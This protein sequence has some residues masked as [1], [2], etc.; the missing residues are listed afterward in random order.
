MKGLNL[1]LYCRTVLLPLLGTINVAAFI[2]ASFLGLRALLACM[3]LAGVAVGGFWTLAPA[4]TADIFGPRA[5]ASNF[6]LIHMANSAGILA[7]NSGV[8]G[9]VYEWVAKRHGQPPGEC[10]GHSCFRYAGSKTLKPKTRK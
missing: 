9:P 6:A 4:C 2:M 1:H 8:V 10:T 7:L 3:I 5:F